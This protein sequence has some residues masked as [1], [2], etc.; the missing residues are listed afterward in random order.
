MRAIILAAG[1]GSR[2]R[3]LTNVT[4]KSLLCVNGK[5]LIETQIEYLHEI[6]INDI[7]ILTG[8]LSTKFNYLT[9]K[10]NVSLKHNKYYD[11]FNN[12]YSMSLIIDKLENSYVIDA[13]VFINNNFLIKEISSSLYFSGK[14][15]SYNEWKLN[16]DDTLKVNEISFSSGDDYIMSGISYWSSKDAKILSEKLSLKMK[17]DSSNWMN[18]YWDDIV[19]ENIK[20]LDVYLFKIKSDDWFEIDTVEDYESLVQKF[21]K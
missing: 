21:S 12:I 14:K 17:L 3:P 16:F 9:E 18:L 11:K 2:L 7:T 1:L 4:P 8:Y 6:G 5:P 10:Y 13:D 20:E 19:K 15:N